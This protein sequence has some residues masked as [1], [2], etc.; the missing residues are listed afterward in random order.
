MNACI[1]C[2]GLILPSG[3]IDSWDRAVCF[4]D[5]PLTED[6]RKSQSVPEGHAILP[7]EPSDAMK[8]AGRMALRRHES[9]RDAWDAMVDM[10][11]M[12]Q[13]VKP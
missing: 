8:F 3:K 10:A 2:K 6:R 11:V 4:C 7:V 9:V 5:E 1:R 12:E 13:R